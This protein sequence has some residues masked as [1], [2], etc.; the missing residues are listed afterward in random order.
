[1]WHVAWRSLKDK[2]ITLLV[3]CLVG[4]GF[5]FMYSAIFPSIK[6]Q[7]DTFNELLKA[8]PMD[9]MKAMGIDSLDMSTLQSFLCMEYFSLLWPILAIMVGVT[10]AGYSLAGEIEAGTMP[11]LLSLPLSRQKIFWGKF[12]ATVMAIAIFT[13]ATTWVVWPIGAIFGAKIPLGNLAWLSLFAF[14]FCLTVAGVA[15]FFSAIFNEKGRAYFISTGI[16][17]LMYVAS[18]VAALKEQFSDLRFVSLFSYFKATSILVYGQI[19]TQI[20]W[21]TL[22][23]TFVL[24]MAACAWFTRKNISV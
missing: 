16:F 9:V 23:V 7:S 8:Y 20:Y 4:I 1:M 13:V 14:L 22:I 5:V 21:F 2:K 3:L 6:S 18:A 17:L 24:V 12:L 11:L 15:T 10:F 19:N